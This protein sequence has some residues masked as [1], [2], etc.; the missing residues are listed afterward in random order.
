MALVEVRPVTPEEYRAAGE[1][2]V[3]AYRALPGASTTA[4][5]EEALADVA[6]RARTAVVLVA[7]DPVVS[8]AP[9]DAT[10][11]LG[12]VTYVEGCGSLWAEQLE[13][14]EASI[15]MLGVDPAAQGRGVGA[16]LLDHCI[17][18]A[19]ESGARALFLH[20]TPWMSAA[21]HLYAKAGFVRVPERD[22]EPTPEVPLLAFRLDLAGA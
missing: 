5:Y 15:R 13:E 8:G 22:W 2:V 6:G 1:V 7:V 10:R 16:A 9:E 3:A 19:R 11:V 14:G 4:G 21:H 12:C 18:R 17:R 20:S